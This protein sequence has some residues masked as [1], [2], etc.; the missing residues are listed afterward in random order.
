MF[1][2]NQLKPD[3]DKFQGVIAPKDQPRT[4]QNLQ[5]KDRAYNIAKLVDQKSPKTNHK[6]HK[7]EKSEKEKDKHS[8]NILYKTMSSLFHSSSH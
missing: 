5:L 1:L 7:K 8:W 4:T 3:W 6:N 2:G